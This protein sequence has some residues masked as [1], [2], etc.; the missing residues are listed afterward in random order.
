MIYSAIMEG[1]IRKGLAL[2]EVYFPEV[3]LS[4]VSRREVKRS[5]DDLVVLPGLNSTHI[6]KVCSGFSG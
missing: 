5:V 3:L 2:L 6:S 4:S 1:D